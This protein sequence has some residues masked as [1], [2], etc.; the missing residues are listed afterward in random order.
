MRLF[1]YH[2]S[3][4]W[5]RNS[6]VS[7]FAYRNYELYIRLNS[8]YQVLSDRIR[9]ATLEEVITAPQKLTNNEI[10]SKIILNNTDE[11]STSEQHVIKIDRSLF[12]NE[13][14]IVR[15]YVIY[16][17]QN[18]NKIETSPDIIG[19]YDEALQNSSIDYLAQIISVYPLINKFSTVQDYDNKIRIII[20]TETRCL[21]SY[22]SSIPCN[23]KLKSDRIYKIIVGGCT[24]TDCT[25][26]LSQSFQTKSENNIFNED[27]SRSLSKAWVAVFPIVAV[28]I[29]SI[30]L[31]IWKRKGLKR[32]C[33]K[34]QKEED[35][36]LTTVD[37]QTVVSTSD[38][39]NFQE[40]KPK[41]LIEYINITDE[42]K[43]VINDEF[44]MLTNLA[45]QSNQS[46]RSSPFDRYQDITSR[47]P[48]EETAVHLT[49]NHRKHDY[50]NANKIRGVNSLKQYIACQSPLKNTCG[51]FWDMIIQYRITKI[52]MLN[53]FDQTNIQD[54]SA[55]TQCY[56][57]IPMNK[58]ETLEFNKIQIQVI[59]IEYYL[60]NQLEIR[61]LLVQKNKK[62]YNIIHFFFT[63]WSKHGTVDCRTL[64]DLIEIVNQYDQVSISLSSPIVVHCSSGTGRTGTYIAVD[65]ITRLLDRSDEQ[66]TRMK[67]DV[68]GIVNQ[69]KHDRTK[70]VQTEK[71][72]LLIHHCVEEY[73]RK[74]NRLDLIINEFNNY[75]TIP[76]SLPKFRE[77]RYI[78]LS[79]SKHNSKVNS[80]SIID[81]VEDEEMKKDISQRIENGQE[82]IN[83]HEHDYVQPDDSYLNN[84]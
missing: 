33:F 72:Y 55:T 16:V 83:E 5:R 21:Q 69:L 47:G 65:I 27:K 62:Q 52:V 57:Y 18:Q 37:L 42:D 32:C 67:L 77:S 19:T 15:R 41:S 63:N 22:D 79:D 81:A 28:L 82:L 40:I 9:V 74:T 45:P 59:N 80:S 66:L 84:Q 44:Q 25:Y 29:P 12:S 58:D 68:M 6:A 3:P 75:Q 54:P 17:R 2:K 13:Y 71:Q 30:G 78:H 35:N 56:P 43:I 50:I 34:K 23:G 14:G 39:Y 10:E 26:V 20:G 11:E 60:D 8:N 73:L 49:D 46:K 7:I 53:Q 70:M 64:I 24:S 1:R 38:V 4:G 31:M 61:R 76:D 51:D 36:N 48:W